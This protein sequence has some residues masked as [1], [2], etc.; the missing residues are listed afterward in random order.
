LGEERN[1]L[2]NI[3]TKSILKIHPVGKSRWN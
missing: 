3:G 1:K 2:F